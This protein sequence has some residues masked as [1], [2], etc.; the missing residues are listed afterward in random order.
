MT[1]STRLLKE[2]KDVIYDKHWLKKAPENLELYYMHRK[3]ELKNKLRY[4]ITI[5]KPLMLGKEFNKTAGHDHPIVPKTNITY[6]ELYEILSGEAIFLLQDS[7]LNQIKDVYAIKTKKG[8]KIIIPPNYEHLM[9]NIGKKELKTCNWVYNEF[10]SNIYKPFRA[11]QGFSYYAIEEKNKIKWIKNNNYKTITP[12]KFKQ[13]NL[14]N[15]DIP[16][17]KSIRKLDP[18]KLDFLKNPEKYQW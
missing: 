6:P 7:E 10:G 15:F 13:P 11:K 12:L 4:D 9:I 3:V 2:M 17:N 5:L 1:K 8:D 16:K 14:Y 18:K